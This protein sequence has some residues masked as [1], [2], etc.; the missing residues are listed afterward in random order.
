MELLNTLKHL[1]HV[2]Y[3]MARHFNADKTETYHLARNY[4]PGTIT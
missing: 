3:R 4:E 2:A 1:H